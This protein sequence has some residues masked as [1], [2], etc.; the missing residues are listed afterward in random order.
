M[1]DALSAVYCKQ[2]SL[3][4]GAG[5]VIFALLKRWKFTQSVEFS[6]SPELLDVFFLS[7]GSLNT[8]EY[9]S[10]WYNISLQDQKSVL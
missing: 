4:E 5:Q 1:N 8:S 2:A 10:S 7:V 3:M 9:I 6:A